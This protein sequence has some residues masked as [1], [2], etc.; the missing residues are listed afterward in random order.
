M[1][2]SVWRIGELECVCGVWASKVYHQLSSSKYRKS[3]VSV[4]WR[5]RELLALSTVVE[6]G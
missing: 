3:V 2:C 4:E 6:M 1:I 5:G